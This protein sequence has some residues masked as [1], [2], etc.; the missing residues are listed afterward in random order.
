MNTFRAGRIVSA[1]MKHSLL[2]MLALWAGDV[3]AK[4][5][6]KFV[7]H[8]WGTFSTFSGSD[9][10]NL[11]FHPNDSDL[12]EFVHGRHRNVKGGVADVL[13][14]LE[15]PVMYFYSDRDRTVSV[16]VDFPKGV[17]TDWYPQASRPPTHDLRW[18]NIKLLTKCGR[19]LPGES[20][21]GRYFAARETD[22]LFVEIAE[23]DRRESEKFLFYRGVG[24]FGMPL[25]VRAQGSGVFNV[26]NT[27]KDM[28]PAFILLR[29]QDGKIAF[30]KFGRLEAGAELKVEEPSA[31]STT[32]KL[33]VTVIALLI[34]QGLYEK[35]ARA[36]VK[37]WRSDWFSEEGT[38]VLYLVS[39][40]VTADFL[41]VKIEPKP[42]QIVRV[43]VGRHDVLSPERERDI[44]S[45]VKRVNG[46]S[47]QDA[48]LADQ[49]L[50]KLGRYRWAAQYAA[51]A[52]IKANAGVRTDR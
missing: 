13:V 52:R 2:V 50:N 18:D 9:G 23:N 31:A 49:A 34:E 30:Q 44:D 24:D 4:E 35:E 19:Q 46:E 43:M 14:S 27:G 51:E 20:E 7:V 16:Q 47:N 26:K 12:P 8:E 41:P 37:T 39:E 21:K 28:V 3:G 15:T 17:M 38:R 5:P 11:K 33:A 29:S 42:D 6:E 10:K 22:S 32:D 25:K 1:A 40:P 45:L 36:M 48:K